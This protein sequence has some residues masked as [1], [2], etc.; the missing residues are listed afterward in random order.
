MEIRIS[1]EEIRKI[2]AEETERAVR[3]RVREMQGDYTSKG[4]L[5]DLIS[6]VLW[7]TICKNIPD[8]ERYLKEKIDNIIAIKKESIDVPS[9]KEVMESLVEAVLDEL[10]D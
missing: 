2:V 8:I 7:D 5:E 3:K 6:K 9:K 10:E 4:Y 1:E